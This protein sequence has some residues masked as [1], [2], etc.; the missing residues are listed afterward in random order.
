MLVPALLVFLLLGCLLSAAGYDVWLPQPHGHESIRIEI[1]L[2]KFSGC[3]RSAKQ[4][5]GS[6]VAAAHGALHGGGPAGVR[7][8]ARQEQTWQGGLLFGTPAIDS[9]L[10]GKRR[11]GFFYDRG[12][13]QFGV[14][15][16]GQRL[17][18]F[19]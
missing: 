14:T 17:P 8:I 13:Q 19:S 16:R 1:W 11:C 6:Q 5:F 4:S 7:P 15:S 9:R 18:D 12:L 10:R 2:Q 3:A